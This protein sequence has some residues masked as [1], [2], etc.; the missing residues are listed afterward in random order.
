M[1]H[2]AYPGEG[3]LEKPKK[4]GHHPEWK[5][6]QRM[7]YVYCIDYIVVVVIFH[8]IF[9]NTDDAIIDCSFGIHWSPITLFTNQSMKIENIN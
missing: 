5:S 9:H 8:A 6:Q 1:G 3:G 4:S 2:P 7:I